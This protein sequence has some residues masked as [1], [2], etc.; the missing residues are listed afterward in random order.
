MASGR[1]HF[2]HGNKGVGRH[3]VAGPFFDLGIYSVPGIQYY[4]RDDATAFRSMRHFVSKNVLHSAAALSIALFLLCSGCATM[5][6]PST[7]L[8]RASE[9][10]NRYP[11]SAGPLVPQRLSASSSTSAVRSPAVHDVTVFVHPAY[12]VFF[13]DAAKDAPSSAKYSLLKK[14]FENEV[15]SITNEIASGKIVIFVIPGNFTVDSSSP[16]SYISYVNTVSAGGRSVYYVLSETSSNGSL[17]LEDMVNLYQF[18]Q[19]MDITRVMIGGGYIGRCQREFYNQLTTY[20]DRSRA[21]IVPEI[22]TISPDDLNEDEALKILGSLERQD[23]TPVRDFMD[24]KAGG[25]ANILSLP[26]KRSL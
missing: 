18:L 23:Y 16:R 5:D 12:A 20:L 24:K 2:C 11:E 26:P 19:A 14:Q 6:Q 9:L 25:A 10:Q 21:F 4:V 22:S 1:D 3:H 8:P 13:R 17:P 7:A 15:R